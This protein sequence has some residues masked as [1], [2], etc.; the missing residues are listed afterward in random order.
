MILFMTLITVAASTASLIVIAFGV[1][2]WLITARRKAS[3]RRFLSERKAYETR[4]AALNRSAVEWYGKDVYL[5]GAT[6]QITCPGWIPAAPIPISNVSVID[7]RTAENEDWFVRELS[8]LISGQLPYQEG[9]RGKFSSRHDAIEA[10]CRPKL[11]ENRICYRLTGVELEPDAA[12]L[13][14]APIR[15]FTGLDVSESLAV[16][17][18]RG[19]KSSRTSRLALRRSLGQPCDLKRNPVHAGVATVTIV[20]HA[21][22]IDRFFLHDR[23]AEAVADGVGQR[24]VVPAGVFQPS[25]NHPGA[26]RPDQDIWKNIV[27]EVC[28]EFLPYVE[29][30][31]SASAP[32]DLETVEPYR[33]VMRLK[34][35]GEIRCFFLGVGLDPVQLQPEILTAMITTDKS[36]RKLF[37]ATFNRA[38]VLNKEGRVIGSQIIGTTKSGRRLIGIPFTDESVKATLATPLVSGAAACL[39]LAWKSH[40]VLVP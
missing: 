20:R 29:E 27:R 26:W 38:T 11:W 4:R 25:T 3:R 14:V 1:T 6:A 13:S 35:N 5:I 39:H 28:E 36:F 30:I 15:F 16:E 12:K 31:D 37:G 7:D 32:I 24:H 2:K 9:A 18:L 33:S 17:M 21:D 23:D 19:I 22:G 8:P 34:Q 10:L 40:S